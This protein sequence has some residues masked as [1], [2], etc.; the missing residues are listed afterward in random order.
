MLASAAFCVL[1][2]GWLAAPGVVFPG[3]V[4]EYLPTTTTPHLMWGEPQPW[5]DLAAAPVDG[6]GDLH[7]LLAVPIS[8]AEK[9]YLEARGYDAL[10][11]KL[12]AAQAEFFDLWRPSVIG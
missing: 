4:A 2:D 7:W 12:G 1:K 9:E 10:D 3:L 8:D 5:P 6:L 11:E